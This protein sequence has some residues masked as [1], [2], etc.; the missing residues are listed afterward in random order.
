MNIKVKRFILTII[1]VALQSAVVA[2]TLKAAIGVGA[3][4]AMGQSFSLLTNI[5]I[6]TIGII[7]NATCVFIELC[8]MK[9]EFGI[10]NLLQLVPALVFGYIENFFYYDVFIFEI[11]SYWISLI[12][13]TV[14]V[15]A[16]SYI[17][18]A[19]MLLNEMT[20]PLEGMCLVIS[21]HFPVRFHMMRQAMDIVALA[22]SIILTLLF[23]Q[24]WTIREGTI[25]A[26]ILYSQ[27]LHIA[28][29]Q[30]TKLFTK[31]HLI[32]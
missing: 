23:S 12:V 11:T 19:I 31:L 10:K 2:L 9:K 14:S 5:R 26:T 6:G 16:A 13:F 20:F 21:N 22:V 1:L 25:I 18:G 29:K 24:Q 7:M 4:D 15:M 17:V 28:I 8:I 27:F 30:E 3:W 32:E